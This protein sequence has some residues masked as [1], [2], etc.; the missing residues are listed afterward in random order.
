MKVF[1]VNRK[2]FVEIFMGSGRNIPYE[3]ELNCSRDMAASKSQKLFLQGT[4]RVTRWRLRE[5]NFWQMLR[6]TAN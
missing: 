1:H 4:A 5:N 3:I 6:F 2:E